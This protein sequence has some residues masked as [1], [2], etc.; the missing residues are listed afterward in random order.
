MIMEYTK[1]KKFGNKFLRVT[2]KDGTIIQ[3][4]FLSYKSREDDFNKVE[5]INLYQKEDEINPIPINDIN[6]IEVVAPMVV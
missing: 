3:G 2:L 4:H 5:K 6:E 1:L